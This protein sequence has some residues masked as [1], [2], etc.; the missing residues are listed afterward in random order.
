MENPVPSA[1]GSPCVVKAMAASPALEVLSMMNRL[2]ASW[3][4]PS[5]E[6]LRGFC[7]LV[8]ATT[9]QSQAEV[10]RC[11]RIRSPGLLELATSPTTCFWPIA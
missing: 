3:F 11:V 8:S 6:A 10:I 1:L 7:R 5:Q 9:G 2:P 4:K